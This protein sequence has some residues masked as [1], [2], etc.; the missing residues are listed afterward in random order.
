MSLKTFHILFIIA[1]TLL[2]AGFGV[3][4]I[5]DYRA[6]QGSTTILV[7]GIVSLVLSGV[8]IAYGRYFLRKLKHIS[9]L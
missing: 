7:L 1:S 8:L 9:Y 6:G 3:W 4:A 2:T 5:W